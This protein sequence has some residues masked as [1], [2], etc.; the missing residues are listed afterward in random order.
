MTGRKVV[1]EP[2]QDVVP[3][4]DVS[5]TLDIP[6]SKIGL[7]VY[8]NPLPEF[9]TTRFRHKFFI[10]GFLQP[11]IFCSIHSIELTGIEFDSI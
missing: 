9:I 10:A 1:L 3:L 2:V 6:L 11:R 7:Y 5:K 8:Y 4:K